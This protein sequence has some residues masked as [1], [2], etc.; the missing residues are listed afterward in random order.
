M[1]RASFFFGGLKY[2]VKMKVPPVWG[3]LA[4]WLIGPGGNLK[5]GID[6]ENSWDVGF[7]EDFKMAAK[8]ICICVK[9]PHIYN[10]F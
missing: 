2:L 5:G 7:S 6:F 10:G 8:Q 4:G 3:R 1:K 9:L